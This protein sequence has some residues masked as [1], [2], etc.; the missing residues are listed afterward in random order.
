M[1]SKSA[2]CVWLLRENSS[3]RKFIVKKVTM[4]AVNISLTVGNIYS[5]QVALLSSTTAQM[6]GSASGVFTFSFP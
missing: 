1:P 4:N 2:I 6:H 5:L 3:G